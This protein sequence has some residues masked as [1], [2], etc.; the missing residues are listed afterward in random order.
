MRTIR[1][2]AGIAVLAVVL[3]ACGG[4]DAPAA[5]ASSDLTIDAGDLYFDPDTVAAPAGEI[6]ITLVNVGAVEHDLLIEEA[7]NANVVHV[8]PGETATGTITL[9]AGTYTFYCDI[10]GHR[11]AGME[12]TLQVG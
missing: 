1:T 6:S 8:D 5:E 3:T 10:P 12:G 2:L 11:A 4:D 9:D 7:G